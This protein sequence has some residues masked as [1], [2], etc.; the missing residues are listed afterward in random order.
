M[1]KNKNCDEEAQKRRSDE[2]VFRNKLQISDRHRF[3]SKERAVNA[4]S[5]LRP[6]VS[7][8]G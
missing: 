5:V 1:R 8:C 3:Y 2:L 6:S 4:S 7:R